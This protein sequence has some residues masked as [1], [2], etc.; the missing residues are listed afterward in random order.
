MEISEENE[1][2]KK[3]FD[4]MIDRVDENKRFLKERYF[5]RE[6]CEEFLFPILSGSI[7]RLFD[8]DR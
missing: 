6:R 7:M 1:H 5:K 3:M 2:Y 8:E 4:L